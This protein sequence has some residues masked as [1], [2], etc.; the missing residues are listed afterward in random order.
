MN[1]TYWRNTIMTA[2]YGSGTGR[3]F[4][5]GLS[6]TAPTAAGGN[7]TEPASANGY[8]RVQVTAFTSPVDGVVKNSAGIVFPS[9][10]GT[11]FPVSSPAAYW[12]MFDG[13]GAG[14]HVLSS[15]TLDEPTS[16]GSNTVVSIPAE[17]I[18]ILLTDGD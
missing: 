6:S 16:I 8:A 11:W 2:I 7:V 4:Y 12:V 17:E 13:A 3:S 15:G 5:V 10:T 1:T 9:S 14:A 18:S